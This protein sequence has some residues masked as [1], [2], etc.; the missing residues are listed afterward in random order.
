[1]SSAGAAVALP[2]TETSVA[3]A[4]AARMI[5]RV[6]ILVFPLRASDQIAFEIVGAEADTNGEA[7]QL[8]DRIGDR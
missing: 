6:F 3:K 5:S 2:L 7:K 4:A 1:M 8:R